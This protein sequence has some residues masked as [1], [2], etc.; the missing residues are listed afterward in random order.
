ME[1]A[2]E[3]ATQCSGLSKVDAII[4]STEEEQVE[5]S[6][7]WTRLS[8]DSDINIVEMNLNMF[9]CSIVSSSSISSS[10][11]STANQNMPRSSQQAAHSVA[12]K[13]LLCLESDVVSLPTITSSSSSSTPF[14]VP[15]VETATDTNQSAAAQLRVRLKKP[16]TT[17]SSSS[18]SLS[19]SVSAESTLLALSSIQVPPPTPFDFDFTFLGTGSAMPSKLRANSAILIKFPPVAGGSEEPFSMLVDAGEGV[20]RQLFHSVSG[21]KDRFETSLL[22]IGIIWISHHHA[23]HLCGLPQL[24]ENIYRARWRRIRAMAK[25]KRNAKSL[26]TDGG[27]SSSSHNNSEHIVKQ[28]TTITDWPRVIVYASASSIAYI[29][30][31]L[32]VSGLDDIVDIQPLTNTVF[33]G[34]TFSVYNRSHGRIQRL[35]SVA[36]YH[37]RESYGLVLDLWNG[38]KFVYSGDCRPS[39]ALIGAGG[40]CDL[41]IHEATFADDCADHAVIKKHSTVSEALAVAASMRVKQLTILTH[42]SQRYAIRPLIIPEII[43]A[44]STPSTMSQTSPPA[45]ASS[46]V[47]PAMRPGRKVPFAVAFDFLRFSFPSHCAVLPEVT[48]CLGDALERV[49]TRLQN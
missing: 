48:N 41:L 43:T 7:L 13:H 8:S 12:A 34:A 19:E 27:D 35:R 38:F 26:A 6:R 32:N 1:A 46:S 36:V 15:T 11:T 45:Q 18:I 14:I 24:V 49:N 47:A 23:D 22:S 42:F 2:V 16:Q 10:N 37:C 25:R 44:T 3:S 28:Y 31:V 17:I 5:E 40:D 33:A 9:E 29:E 4:E 20:S 30:Y 21:N 39:A